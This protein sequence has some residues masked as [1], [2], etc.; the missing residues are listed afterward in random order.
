MET[1]VPV[2]AH[3]QLIAHFCEDLSSLGDVF[4]NDAF[5]IAHLNH[6]SIAGIQTS[7]R[8]SGLLMKRELEIFSQVCLLPAAVG[9][10]VSFAVQQSAVYCTVCKEQRA[11]SSSTSSSA[12][13]C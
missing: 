3:P 7:R 2:T 5:S 10:S 13:S 12:A 9:L 6:S 11:S 8:V 1:L 4:V